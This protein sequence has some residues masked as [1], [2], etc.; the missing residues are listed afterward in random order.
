MSAMMCMERRSLIDK[1]ESSEILDSTLKEMGIP[2]E[3][4][5]DSQVI[6]VAGKIS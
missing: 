6:R 1:K 4:K 2:I 3:I 5:N